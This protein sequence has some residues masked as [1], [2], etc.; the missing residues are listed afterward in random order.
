MSTQIRVSVCMATYNGQNYIEEQL[1]SIINEI[2]EDGEIVI[3][4]DCSTDRTVE[5]IE[6]FG[7][8]RIRVMQNLRNLGVNRTFERA[9]KLCRGEYIFLADQDDIWVAGRVASMLAALAS[10]DICLVTTNY[11]K[12]G[13]ASET[14]FMQPLLACES[15]RHVLNICRIFLGRANYYGCAMAIKKGFLKL[16]L[17]FPLFVESHDLWIAILANVCRS[18]LHLEEPSLARR[19]HGNNVSVVSRP[20]LSRIGSRVLFCFHLFV[21]FYRFFLKVIYDFRK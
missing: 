5:L 14:G 17:P 4:D 16:A 11:T 9:L 19:I 18:N 10:R 15:K 12:F 20:I 8:S 13:H 6:N 21:A 3:V 1:T 2:G 7:D